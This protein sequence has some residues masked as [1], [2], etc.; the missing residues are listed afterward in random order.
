MRV[1]NPPPPPHSMT[2]DSRCV[3]VVNM[4]EF[5][6]FC[7][8]SRHVDTG[9]VTWFI[10]SPQVCGWGGGVTRVILIMRQEGNQGRKI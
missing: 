8:N 6:P 10:K 9:G 7:L 5:V 4:E 1:F 2:V 3:C